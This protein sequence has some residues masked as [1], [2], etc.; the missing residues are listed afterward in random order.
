MPVSGSDP[1]LNSVYKK[2]LIFAHTFV[3]FSTQRNFPPAAGY[4]K[5]FILAEYLEQKF[6]PSK[7]IT[8]EISAIKQIT[9]E[10]SDPKSLVGVGSIKMCVYKYT[11][12]EC[13]SKTSF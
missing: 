11:C 6:L 13:I 3:I 7:F 12:K 4:K 1:V 5:T 9:P 8:A 2:K 10:I